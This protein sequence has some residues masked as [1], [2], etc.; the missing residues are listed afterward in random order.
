MLPMVM[1]SSSH[2]PNSFLDNAA[3]TRLKDAH[4]ANLSMGSYMMSA[5]Q[6]MQIITA[7]EAREAQLPKQ[8]LRCLQRL[9]IIQSTRVSD[10]GLSILSGSLKRLEMLDVAGCF[11][12]SLAGVTA[13][14]SGGVVRLRHLDVNGWNLERIEP[15]QLDVFVSSLERLSFAHCSGVIRNMKHLSLLRELRHLDLSEGTGVTNEELACMST[16]PFLQHLNLAFCGKMV[17]DVGLEHISKMQQLKWL[18]VTW[19]T[20][21]TDVGVAYLKRL[22]NLT[23]LNI[24]ACNLVTDAG[25]VEGVCKLRRLEYVDLCGLFRITDISIVAIASSLPVLRHIALASCEELTDAGATSLASLTHLQ[26]V[27]VSCCSKLSDVCLSRMANSLFDLEHLDISWCEGGVTDKGI[28]A[29]SHSLRKLNTFRLAGC[30]SVT[31][32]GVAAMF[33]SLRVLQL[34][35][36]QDCDA[37]SEAGL[38]QVGALQEYQSLHDGKMAAA[39]DVTVMFR[40]Q[41][42]L[43]HPNIHKQQMAAVK[44]KSV[45]SST[46]SQHEQQQRQQMIAR[47]S[48]SRSNSVVSSSLPPLQNAKLSTTK[49]PTSHHHRRQSGLLSNQ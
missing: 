35:D 45:S 25:I 31:N 36:V 1:M 23:H 3:A 43:L 21:V 5:L 26:H 30:T 18:D 2:D 19:C 46:R 27:N 9:S 13:F 42:Y 7:T 11:K 24:S 14:I 17:S 20:S 28:A 39:G 4:T 10:R 48:T 44:R 47:R 37:I 49:L 38:T 34:L 33:A 15:R 32:G 16:I 6:E 40:N 22:D 29:L 8:P 41:K 12:T